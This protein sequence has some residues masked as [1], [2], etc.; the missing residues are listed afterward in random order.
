M[1]IM[2]DARDVCSTIDS[3]WQRLVFT[4]VLEGS[5]IFL[6]QRARLSCTD[7]A[8]CDLARR[9]APIQAMKSQILFVV[10]I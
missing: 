9:F 5:H 3:D 1:M 4:K 7:H 2:S 10:V 6:T 8:K